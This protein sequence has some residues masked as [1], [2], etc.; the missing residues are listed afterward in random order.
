MTITEEQHE[1]NLYGIFV[2]RMAMELPAAINE[3]IRVQLGFA[4]GMRRSSLKEELDGVIEAGRFA[5]WS[6]DA[7]ADCYHQDQNLFEEEFGETSSEY[8]AGLP[9]PKAPEGWQLEFAY[10]AMEDLDCNS[11]E[12]KLAQAIRMMVNLLR[13][14]HEG[15]TF[16]LCETD[17]DLIVGAVIEAS[18]RLDWEDEDNNN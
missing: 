2:K 13:D 11:A 3:L 5:E 10:V 14:I 12:F 9:D 16:G 1:E 6:M 18:R 17:A 4:T 15:C 8:L 7:S